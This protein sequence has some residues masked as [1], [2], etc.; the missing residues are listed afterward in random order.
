MFNRMGKIEDKR[1]TD[2]K[3]IVFGIVFI[4]DGQYYKLDKKYGTLL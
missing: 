3:N 1:R 4:E 2:P